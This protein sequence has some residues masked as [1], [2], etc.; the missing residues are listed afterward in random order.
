MLFDLSHLSVVSDFSPLLSQGKSQ[1][2]RDSIC[3]RSWAAA[4]LLSNYLSSVACRLIDWPSP[5]RQL[6]LSFSV[7][8]CRPRSVSLSFSLF[9]EDRTTFSDSLP[10]SLSGHYSLLSVLLSLHT[11]Y[12]F[13]MTVNVCMSISLLM[14]ALS[15][16]PATNNLC[17]TSRDWLLSRTGLSSPA[18]CLL[19]NVVYIRCAPRHCSVPVIFLH[20]PLLSVQTLSLQMLLRAHFTLELNIL[21]VIVP[22]RKLH[23]DHFFKVSSTTLIRSGTL[24]WAIPF[25]THHP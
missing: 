8:L 10:L 9:L 13:S 16:C 11:H 19:Y 21:C 22:W 24:N 6:S 7:C 15:S 1:Q 4:E 12:L 2:L 23:Y 25:P 14:T 18:I 5:L 20:V 3:G 17:P